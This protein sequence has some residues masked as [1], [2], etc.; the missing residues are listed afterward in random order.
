MIEINRIHDVPLK[1]EMNTLKHAYLEGINF[2]R[3]LL[4]NLDFSS[5]FLDNIDFRSAEMNN[6]KFLFA[7]FDKSRLIMVEAKRSIFDKCSFKKSFLLHSDFSDS[8]FRFADLSEGIVSNTVFI[9]CDLRGANMSCSGL[10]TC[11]LE[12]A[13]YDETTIWCENF[14]AMECGAIKLE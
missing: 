10:E 7:V 2:H 13:I 14:N 4:N 1:L 12:G 6:S 5:S 11:V 3:C 9:K 8:S